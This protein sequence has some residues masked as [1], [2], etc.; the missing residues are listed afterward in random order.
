VDIRPPVP[1]TELW[2]GRE[3]Y[4]I[5]ELTSLVRIEHWFVGDKIANSLRLSAVL[6]AASLARVKIAKAAGNEKL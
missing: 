3:D 2:L 1:P 5:S 6:H 4:F